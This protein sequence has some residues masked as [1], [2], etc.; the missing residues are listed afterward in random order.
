MPAFRVPPPHCWLHG[1]LVGSCARFG[2]RQ[3]LRGTSETVDPRA[4]MH[5]VDRVRSPASTVA[6]R[7][8]SLVI[9]PLPGRSLA[10]KTWPPFPHKRWFC[11]AC[12]DLRACCRQRGIRPQ[13]RYPAKWR[14]EATSALDRI[15]VAQ[16]PQRLLF[17]RSGVGLSCSAVQH[18]C[19]CDVH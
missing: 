12:R 18:A 14:R 16:R 17:S 6:S 10:N 13:W 2:T 11:E 8:T 3:K 19:H 7:A 4:S 5:R 1:R 15:L 9:A